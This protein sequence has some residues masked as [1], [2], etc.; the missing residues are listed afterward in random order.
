MQRHGVLLSVML[1]STLSNGCEDSDDVVEYADS[2]AD[3]ASY[4]TFAFTPAPSGAADLPNEVQSSLD[5]VNSELKKQLE[6]QGLTEV[7]VSAS[8]DVVVFSLESTKD[9]S[10]LSWSCVPG[11][12]YG[13]WPWTYDPCSVMAPSYD[14][15]KSGSIAVGLVDP[16]LQR[17]VF[18]GVAESVVVG[19]GNDIQRLV[20]GAVDDIFKDY[21]SDQTGSG[22]DG[23][24]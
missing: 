22:P 17:V 8:P 2:Q 21:P 12:W 5:V 24:S 11:Y 15:Y 7:N 20:D 18:G 4:K 23:G 1:A 9:S 3:F 16:A 10:A 13:Y 19:S 6:E 14:E